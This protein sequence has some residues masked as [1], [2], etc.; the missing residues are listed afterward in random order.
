ME[1]EYKLIFH[2]VRCLTKPTYQPG[3][4]RL[5]FEIDRSLEPSWRTHLELL[6]GS[7]RIFEHRL[8]QAFS[9]HTQTIWYL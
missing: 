6:K 9:G 7:E 5:Q 2:L 1:L 4:D 8:V 3:V